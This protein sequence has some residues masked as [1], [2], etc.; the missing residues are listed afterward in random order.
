MRGL[1]KIVFV[2]GVL[3]TPFLA[4]A[5]TEYFWSKSSPQEDDGFFEKSCVSCSYLPLSLEFGSTF[6]SSPDWIE[7]NFIDV[8]IEIATTTRNTYPNDRIVAVVCSGVTGSYYCDGSKVIASS[9]AILYSSLDDVSV[10][11]W[12]RF[13][14][15]DPFTWHWGTTT[16]LYI[17][18]SLIDSQRSD[19]EVAGISPTTAGYDSYACW[20]HSQTACGTGFD[21]SYSAGYE[22]TM[23]IGRTDFQE[24]VL[25]SHGTNVYTGFSNWNVYVPSANVQPEYQLRVKYGHISSGSY[26]YEDTY[27]F[28][29]TAINSVYTVG[30]DNATVFFLPSATTTWYVRPDV[31][32][33]DGVLVEQGVESVFYAAPSENSLFGYTGLDG[34]PYFFNL[35]S[36]TNPEV[37]ECDD[38]LC[39]VMVGLFKP[40]SDKATRF[41]ALWEPLYYKKPWGYLFLVSEQFERLEEATTSTSTALTFVSTFISSNPHVEEFWDLIRSGIAVLVWLTM[42]L[43]LLAIIK[44]II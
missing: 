1:L 16:K 30:V 41:V 20:T 32:D 3:F 28:L 9:T 37:I 14:F 39:K 12:T 19:V 8:R 36:T 21:G 2:L 25:P 31:Y 6:Q 35:G 13:S 44:F 4:S 15:A 27:D 18:F 42:L 22:A 26:Q 24:V 23:R 40:D 17:Q 43:F 38:I 7:A 10:N 5:D 11:D 33:S 29:Y 34:N